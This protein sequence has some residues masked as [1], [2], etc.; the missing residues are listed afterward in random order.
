MARTLFG[1][2]EQIGYVV[3]DLDAA[4]ARWSERLGLGPWTVFRSTRLEGHFRGTP[5]RVMMDV[6]L[7]Y[8]GSLQIELIHVRSDTPSPYMVD[9]RPL[10]GVHHIA[11]VVDDLDR[12]VAGAEVR[13]LQPVFRAGNE[14]VRVAYL[15]SPGE[16]GVLYEL[17]EGAAMREMI[18]AG[19]AATAAWDG[20]DPIT[21]I[22]LGEGGTR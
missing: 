3:A 10:T 1:Q 7:A 18:A 8:Q 6:A 16:D 4:V 15:E 5:T 11:W 14:A 17:I 12:T 2:V 9:G 13:G 19:I 22:D 20:R 21:E